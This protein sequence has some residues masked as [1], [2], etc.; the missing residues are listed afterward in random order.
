MLDGIQEAYIG[1]QM[2]TMLG[3]SR[4]LREAGG[5]EWGEDTEIQAFVPRAQ[6]RLYE[7][8]LVKKL[9]VRVLRWEYIIFIPFGLN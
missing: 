7:G 8:E 3:V 5:K 4:I 9:M 1:E 6:I 2:M